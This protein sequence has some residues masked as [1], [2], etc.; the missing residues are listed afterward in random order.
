[1]NNI[2]MLVKN[3]YAIIFFLVIIFSLISIYIINKVAIPIISNYAVIETKKIGIEVL[4]NTGIKEVNEKLK[5]K[6]F[7]ITTFNKNNEIET[8]D[9][10][11][12]I[13]NEAMIE[14]AKNVRKRL[15]ET[16]EG[17]KLP[18]EMYD[19]KDNKY[20]KKG[21]I[22]E[23]PLGLV[24]NNALL[25]NVGPRIPVKIKYSGNVG[26]DIKTKVKQYGINSA[27]LEIYVYIEVTQKA[28]LP[29]KTKEVK[30]TSEVPIIIKLVKGN[31]PNY[32]TT[33]NNSYSLPID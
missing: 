24:F 8:I 23:I 29:F 16:E 10:D 25:M 5:D 31:I 2:K 9:F 18:E 7:L 1:M 26:L 14:I 21:I 20:L 4:R 15:K 3:I 6:N 27:L 11:T 28:I 17:K 30:L 32:I 33:Q 12:K 19:N 13:I 22:Y